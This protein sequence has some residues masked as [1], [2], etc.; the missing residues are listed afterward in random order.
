[1]PATRGGRRPNL[2]VVLSPTGFE[3]YADKQAR[4]AELLEAGRQ[5]EREERARREA[6]GW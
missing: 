2:D 5:A 4:I 3:P 1:M 6:E